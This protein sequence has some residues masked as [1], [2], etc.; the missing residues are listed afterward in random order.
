MRRSV[1]ILAAAGLLAASAAASAWVLRARPA[2]SPPSAASR[3]GG[4]FSLIDPQGRPVTDRD[5][6]G[7][8]TVVYFGFTYCPEVCPTT[9]A[10]M[11]RWLKA[12][13]PDAEKL[14]LVFITIDPERD[15]PKQL[16]LYLA[17]FDHRIRGLTG[18]PKAVSEAAHDYNVYYQ[19]VALEGGGYTM[20]H[21]TTVY[22]MDARGQLSDVIAYKEPDADAIAKLRQLARD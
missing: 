9:L 14:N 8:P 21:S 6:L 2:A 7:K 4:R 19:K 5:L 1:L 17:N 12:I 13:G 22:L 11:T 20:D 18:S 15:T 16:R 10:S 3:L